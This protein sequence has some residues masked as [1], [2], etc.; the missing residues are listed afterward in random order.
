MLT[1]THQQFVGLSWGR[2]YCGSASLAGLA[3]ASWQTDPSPSAQRFS[4]WGQKQFC[5]VIYY[6][7]FHHASITHYCFLFAI[8]FTRIYFLTHPCTKTMQC[9]QCEG[10]TA[11]DFLVCVLTGYS[12]CYIIQLQRHIHLEMAGQNNCAAHEMTAQAYIHSKL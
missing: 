8:S 7:P 10:S 6:V 2:S 3:G 4:H 11:F 12:T 5:L 9:I 1:L